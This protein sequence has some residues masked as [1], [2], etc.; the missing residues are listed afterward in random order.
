[1]PPLPFEIT[2]EMAIV[3]LAVGFAI[4]SMGI[5]VLA[6]NFT[7][8]QPERIVRL[9]PPDDGSV[10]LWYEGMKNDEEEMKLAE[11]QAELDMFYVALLHN[12]GWCS[13]NQLWELVEEHHNSKYRGWEDFQHRLIKKDWLEAALRRLE[14][15]QEGARVIVIP[16]QGAGEELVHKAYV[17][18]SVPVDSTNGRRLIPVDDLA[19]SYKAT[20]V[21]VRRR[22]RK[23]E[24]APR[25]VSDP[26]VI[27]GEL[28][29]AS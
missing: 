15:G 14:W 13:A 4:F 28:V 27:E 7:R 19:E 20:A 29:F 12:D 18:L 11:R 17:M 3:G 26:V 6:L 1:M 21:R 8:K 5:T 2:Q 24:A 25:T 23:E 9:D 16:Q 22:I 10:R